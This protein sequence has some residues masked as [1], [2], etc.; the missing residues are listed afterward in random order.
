MTCYEN[1][2]VHTKDTHWMWV[3]S[4]LLILRVLEEYHIIYKSRA[5]LC[6]WNNFTCVRMPTWSLLDQFYQL[7]TRNAQIIKDE[8][9]KRHCSLY[10]IFLFL[11]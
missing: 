5:K 9:G 1:V 7:L 10:L 4:E 3:L 6:P 2:D 8:T 11:L